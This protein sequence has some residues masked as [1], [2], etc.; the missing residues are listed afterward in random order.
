MD[1]S[2]QNNT[3]TFDTL[4]WLKTL[5]IEEIELIENY[6]NSLSIELEDLNDIYEATIKLQ[7]LKKIKISIPLDSKYGFIHFYTFIIDILNKKTVEYLAIDLQVEH[8]NYLAEH[9]TIGQRLYDALKITNI[10]TIEFSNGNVRASVNSINDDCK[11]ASSLFSILDYICNNAT[12]E[13]L[14]WKDQCIFESLCDRN[15]AKL[16]RILANLLCFKR[17]VS[18]E[19]NIDILCAIFENL[20]VCENAELEFFQCKLVQSIERNKRNKFKTFFVLFTTFISAAKYLNYLSIDL[21]FPKSYY[22]LF[23]EITDFSLCLRKSNITTLHVGKIPIFGWSPFINKLLFDFN[24][25]NL[26]VDVWLDVFHYQ[27]HNLLIN[28]GYIIFDTFCNKNI[29]IIKYEHKV[30]QLLLKYMNGAYNDISNVIYEYIEPKLNIICKNV[31]SPKRIVLPSKKYF[32]PKYFSYNE[33]FYVSHKHTKY[34]ANQKYCLQ[35]NAIKYAKQ[36]K[37]KLKF[38]N[39]H[40]P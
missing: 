29:K 11:F 31:K 1:V 22:S 34:E 17:K 28:E 16:Y 36:K 10:R 12:I 2:I 26:T 20:A 7:N 40:L 6:T 23:N 27:N 33:N 25:N 14:I 24:G 37:N 38:F 8:L 9:C 32:I 19:V 21:D 5:H 30:K 18:F 13:N 15:S 35:L 3:E 39:I 4:E